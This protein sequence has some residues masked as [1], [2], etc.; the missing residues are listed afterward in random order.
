MKIIYLKRW[1]EVV[2]IFIQVFMVMILASECDDFK[3]F[4][5][6]KI[7]ALLIFMFNHFI[8]YKYSRL[9]SD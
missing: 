5:I 4:I 2:I 7:I 3:I 6:S 1:V 8:L 9:A